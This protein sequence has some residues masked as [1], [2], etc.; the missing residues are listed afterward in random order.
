[1]QDIEQRKKSTHEAETEAA[2]ERDLGRVV[3]ED[4]T[5]LHRAHDRGDARG[6]SLGER[7]QLDRRQQCPSEIGKRAPRVVRWL[8]I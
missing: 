5:T 2:K 1:M 6:A 8:I 7:Q 3:R 4:C